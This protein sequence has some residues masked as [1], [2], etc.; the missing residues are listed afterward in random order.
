[1]Q[2][3]TGTL[4]GPE[5]FDPIEQEKR[6]WL[7]S[8]PVEDAD[9]VLFLFE[10]S[11]KALD[12]FFNIANHPRRRSGEISI[13]QDLRVEIAVADR[14]MRGLLQLCRSVLRQ[15][16]TSAFVFRSY[17]ETQLVSDLE[18]DA[19]LAYHQAQSTPLESLYLLQIG[20]KS[21][22]DI[23]SALL[24]SDHVS[25]LAFRALGH[26][27]TSLIIQNRYFNPLRNRSFSPMYDRVEHPLLQ[28]AV[29]QAP[30]ERMRRGLSMLILMLNR[31]LR[32]NS[33]IRP[34]AT[35]K[36]ELYDALPYLALLRSDF[37]TLIPYLESSFAQR[38]FPNG[39]VLPVEKELLGRVDAFA[40]QL[41]METRKVFEQLLLDYSQITSIANL[42]SGLEAAHGLLNS[43]LQQATVSL[44]QTVLPDV[45]GKDIFEDFISRLEQSKRLRE[46]IWI[47][48]EILADFIKRFYDDKTPIEE[49]RRAYAGLL[50]FINHFLEVT[51]K[52][53][54]AADHEA[55]ANF[56]ASVRAL[57]REGFDNPNRTREIARSFEHF[58]I[59]LE[60][61]IGHINQRSE[62]QNVALDQAHA[63]GLLRK[64]LPTPDPF[65]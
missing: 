14:R 30:S 43:F 10:I 58:R 24:A 3:P 44:V 52:L 46:D 17:V 26:Q 22:S 13:D 59:Y 39:P 18:R 42:R 25:L 47:F 54:R 2:N 57:E 4:A 6:A 31:Y 9:E 38:L 32:V 12:R 48:H 53:V 45:Q 7:A 5:E 28:H 16:D 62:L 11:I 61:T 15:T 40:F 27:Y 63:A 8:V 37:R 51:Y 60:T 65:N 49:R 50:K 36:E 33:W 35:T 19:L 21:L 56:F 20:L 29:R 23:S 64:F 55:F 34:N 1:M 41:S